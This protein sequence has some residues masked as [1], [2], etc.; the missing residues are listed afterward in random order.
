[1]PR[2]LF[3][4]VTATVIF[5]SGLVTL[6]KFSVYAIGLSTLPEDTMAL[7]VKLESLA[8]YAGIIPD[9]VPWVIFVGF[10]FYVLAQKL[11]FDFSLFR[12][13]TSPS[14][15]GELNKLGKKAQIIAVNI[16]KIA[17]SRNTY[18]FQKREVPRLMG[19]IESAL[20]SF[21]KQGFDIPDFS[22]A[23]DEYG[24]IKVAERYFATLGEYL[25]ADHTKEARS[26]A[27]RHHG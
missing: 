23:E 14:N 19:N 11:G 1:M 10:L 4:V 2:F 27:K 21:K 8:K 17:P 7:G 6:F 15:G 26:Y 5:I 20:I 3:K 16:S 25:S 9:W 13:V 24:K 12:P 18:R 22:I